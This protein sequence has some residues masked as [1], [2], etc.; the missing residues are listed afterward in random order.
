MVNF[1]EALRQQ[2]QN[3]DMMMMMVTMAAREKRTRTAMLRRSTCS[4]N[5]HVLSLILLFL[6]ISPEICLAKDR[7]NKKKKDPNAAGGVPLVAVT[8]MEALENTKSLWMVVIDKD[9]QKTLSNDVIQLASLVEGLYR[10]GIVDTATETGMDIATK[11]LNQKSATASSFPKHVVYGDGLARVITDTS[12]QG[13]ANALIS[14]TTELL[15]SRAT[16]MGAAGG[17][18]AGGSSSSSSSSSGGDSLVV[19]LNAGNFEEL[20]YKSGAASLVAFTAPWCGHCQRLLP[21]WDQASL[22]LGKQVG[23]DVAFLGWVDATADER[24]AAEYQVRGYPTIY[25]LP[26]GAKSPKDGILYQGERT[27]TSVAQYAMAQLEKYGGLTIPQLLSP[28][29]MENKCGGP[30]HLCVM[31]VLPHLADTTV[32]ARNNHLAIVQ[33]ISKKFPSVSFLWSEGTSQPSLEQAFGLTFGYPAVV[34]YTMDR[35]AFAVMRGSFSEKSMTSFL[36]SITTGR[37]A[38]QPIENPP[39][40]GAVTKWDGKAWEGIAEDEF[41]LEDIM[42]EEL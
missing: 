32:D 24:L 11:L 10:V 9:P 17:G 38:T 21:E 13:M 29:D 26:P 39:K 41:S 27:A 4:W 42:G 2:T 14:A 25:F 28:K 20:V 36:H 40:V 19:Q 34:A 23:M 15:Q 22:M 6:A 31:T 30:N 1:E 35:C 8:A 16:K 3:R 37:I 7:Q 12:L 18:S 33:A 5:A